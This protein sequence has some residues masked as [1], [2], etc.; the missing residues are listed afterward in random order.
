MVFSSKCPLYANTSDDRSLS[1]YS[2][3]AVELTPIEFAFNNNEPIELYINHPSQI[4]SFIETCEISGSLRC[5][6]DMLEPGLDYYFYATDKY[7][8]RLMFENDS[9]NDLIF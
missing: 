2:L 3:C 4:Y 5:W 8:I 7:S 6:T 9:E 1:A